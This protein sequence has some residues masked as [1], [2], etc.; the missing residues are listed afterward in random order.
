[1]R[2]SGSGPKPLSGLPTPLLA[3]PRPRRGSLRA[4]ASARRALR[5]PSRRRGLRGDPL[6]VVAGRTPRG[7]LGCAGTS[8]R[9]HH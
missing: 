4:P 1:V 3:S 9:R 8:T 6:T 2:V 5:G 7:A